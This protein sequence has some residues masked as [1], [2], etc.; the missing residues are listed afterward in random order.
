M[1]IVTETAHRAILHGHPKFAVIMSLSCDR[2]DCEFSSECHIK[3][4]ESRHIDGIPIVP[5]ESGIGPNAL[6]NTVP[7]ALKKNQ[8][9][10]VYGHGVF[11]AAVEDFNQP[12][13]DLIEIEARCRAAYFE[14]LRQTGVWPPKG[15]NDG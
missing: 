6:C 4:P 9:V 15:T 7:E 2:A 8:S 1:R 12:L 13:H 10:I 14:A 11:A 5:G 3:C